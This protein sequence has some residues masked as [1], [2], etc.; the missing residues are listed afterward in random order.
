MSADIPEPPLPSTE[1]SSTT[2][3][4]DGACNESSEDQCSCL[5]RMIEEG[6]FPFPVI[7]MSS[8]APPTLAMSTAPSDIA[9]PLRLQ[10]TAT[11]SGTAPYLNDLSEKTA[12]KVGQDTGILTE[13]MICKMTD[14]LENG[15]LYRNVS[16]LST[17]DTTVGQSVDDAKKNAKY[18]V[19]LLS[20][21]LIYLV[22]HS[23]GLMG[24]PAAGVAL[25]AFCAVI[26]VSVV[27]LMYF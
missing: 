17:G 5:I 27:Y 9:H 6:V 26:G 7:D 4:I 20:G 12:Q 11:F 23:I 22:V 18:V 24:G 2:D 14:T 15:D 10:T 16:D 8:S 21:I 13:Y 25:G 1:V 19:L 3:I